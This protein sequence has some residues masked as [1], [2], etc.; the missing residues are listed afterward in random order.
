MR[1]TVTVVLIL[2]LLF[3][4]AFPI[5]ALAEEKVKLRFT[6]WGS[7]FEKEALGNAAKMYEQINPNAEVEAIHIPADYETKITAMVAAGEAPDLAMLDP[8]YGLSWAEGGLIYNLKEFMDK[9]PDYGVDKF[10]PQT[11]YKWGEDEIFGWTLQVYTLYYN[12]AAFDTA[13]VAYPPAK[14]EDAWEWDEFVEVAK[15]LTLDQSGRNATDPAF[16]P[17]QIRQYGVQYDTGIDSIVG[18]VVSNGGDIIDETGTTFTMDQPAATEAVQKIADLMNVHHVAPSP[19]ASA[20]LPAAA[21][22]LQSGQVAM[23]ITGQYIMIDL[24]AAELDYDIGVLPKFKRSMTTAFGSP[25]VIFKDTEHPQEA[26]DLLKLL[27]NPEGSAPLFEGGLWMPYMLKWYTEP[28]YVT[29]WVDNAAHPKNYRTAIIDQMLNN[30]TPGVKFYVKNV[31]EV[32]PIVQPALERVFL[33]SATAE[34]AMGAIR[35]QV[36]GVLKGR[37]PVNY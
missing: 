6:Y 12:K 36:N 9:D 4:I 18:A 30:C 11:L 19:A 37:Y 20:N 10:M 17:T 27:R 1:R 32:L 34:E 14:V 7:Q 21:V 31:R 15:Q 3:S 29:K 13:G 25:A 16:D 26:W 22:G 5:A 33:G 23:A 2:A 24:A 8:A 28:E 35:E